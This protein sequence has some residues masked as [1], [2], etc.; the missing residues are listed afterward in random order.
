MASSGGGKKLDLFFTF[1]LLAYAFLIIPV[2]SCANT[3]VKLQ[4]P[5]NPDNRPIAILTALQERATKT[6]TGIVR[7]WMIGLQILIFFTALPALIESGEFGQ[8]WSR[9]CIQSKGLVFEPVRTSLVLL[10]P[11]LFAQETG[12]EAQPIRWYSD[13]PD[14]EIEAQTGA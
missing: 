12:A 14:K 9:G 1:P 13:D 4:L 6:K 3:I 8:I 7:D 5:E 10:I 2:A 11:V